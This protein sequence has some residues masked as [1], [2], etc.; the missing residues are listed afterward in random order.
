MSAAHTALYRIESLQ[1]GHVIVTTEHDKP[2][3][4]V[5]LEPAAHPLHHTVRAL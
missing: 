3:Q 5:V 2:D 4:R 1:T